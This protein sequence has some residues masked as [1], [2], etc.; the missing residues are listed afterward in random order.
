METRCTAAGLMG[1]DGMKLG[2][3][4]AQ[5][6]RNGL[7]SAMAGLAAGAAFFAVCALAAPVAMAM[8]DVTAMSVVLTMDICVSLF[9]EMQWTLR[10]IRR[11]I[12]PLH[13]A[14]RAPLHFS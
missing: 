12:T 11:L 14:P 9:I 7:G 10:I 8:A 13:F 1:L 5:E 2:D 4:R 6:I 3:G